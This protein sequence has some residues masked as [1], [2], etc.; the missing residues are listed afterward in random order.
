MN[1]LKW[2]R[3]VALFFLLTASVVCDSACGMTSADDDASLSDERLVA[4]RQAIDF[5]R[6][7]ISKSEYFEAIV[8]LDSA[9][10]SIGEDYIDE[11]ALD[12]T[13][14]KLIIS[15][16][17]K[18]RGNLA[19]SA[20]LKLSV[21]V[22]RIELADRRVAAH[23]LNMNGF[24]VEHVVAAVRSFSLCV[25]SER[26]VFDADRKICGVETESRAELRDYLV[27]LAQNDYMFSRRLEVVARRGRFL[28]LC[29]GRPDV[30]I[31]ITFDKGQSLVAAIGELLP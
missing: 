21:L 30:V 19:V 10:T 11:A 22:S 26:A 23:D 13:P 31:A 7:L 27:C 9:I 28:Y 17:E 29:A 1:Q 20:N 15:H 3:F 12:D 5:A 25:R 14:M 18:E 6:S 16:F 2:V 4:G 8:V 24:S